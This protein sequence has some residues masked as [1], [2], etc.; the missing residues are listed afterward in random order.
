MRKFVFM[1]LLMA[2]ILSMATFAMAEEQLFEVKI[3]DL[4]DNYG[5]KTNW[6]NVYLNDRDVKNLTHAAAYL[7]PIT[8][9]DFKTD[10]GHIVML[11]AISY[12]AG[13]AKLV[14]YPIKMK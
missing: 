12:K 3:T 4:I 6:G 11:K 9:G 1:A 10:K 8:L 5:F 14:V 2:F 13:V 7:K